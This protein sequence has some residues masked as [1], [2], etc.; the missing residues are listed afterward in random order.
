MPTLPVVDATYKLGVEEVPT[1]IPPPQTVSSSE[2][3]VVPM[4]T[5]PPAKIVIFDVLFVKRS[6]WPLPL[7]PNCIPFELTPRIEPAADTVG[8]TKSIYRPVAPTSSNRKGVLLTICSFVEGPV[9]PMPT[10]PPEV[11]TKA[12]VAVA[13]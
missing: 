9:V 7:T 10:C 1:N 8:E 4:P 13:T 6:N 3:V 5:L 11:T 12:G 2:G